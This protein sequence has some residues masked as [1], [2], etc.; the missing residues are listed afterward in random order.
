M[1][2]SLS[3]CV[4]PVMNWQAAFGV[5]LP[6]AVGMLGQTSDLMETHVNKWIKS[7]E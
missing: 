5:S 1:N 7:T 2:L 3:V 4:G 6:S